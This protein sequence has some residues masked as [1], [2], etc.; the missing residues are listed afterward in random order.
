MPASFWYRVFDIVTMFADIL[1]RRYLKEIPS[2]FY[3]WKWTKDLRK[4]DLSYSIGGSQ[5]TCSVS[6]AYIRMNKKS[7]Q[8]TNWKSSLGKL[9]TRWKFGNVLL[10]NILR[11]ANL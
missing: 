10:N 7:I 2:V 8:S 6:L 11:N 3:S 5:V 9:T 4:K 1:N